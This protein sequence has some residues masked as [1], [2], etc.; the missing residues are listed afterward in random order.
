MKIR[1]RSL[2]LACLLC[3]ASA[4]AAAQADHA[5]AADRCEAAVTETIEK[6]RGKDA[7]D[8]QFVGAKRALSTNDDDEVG[9]KGEGRYRGAGGASIPF[10]YSCAF[11]AKS[12][13][14]SGVVFRETGGAKPAAADKPWQPDL[15]NVSPQ[16][17]EAAVASALKGKYPRVGG[18]SFS[19]A[20]RQVKPAADAHMSLEGQ[21]VMERAPGMSASPFRYRCEID[22]RSG[23]ILRAQT[24]E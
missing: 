6:L 1:F 15:S 14:T 2:G 23:K 18:I 22:P 11:N 19:A 20:T 3:A 12:S 7:Q 5:K 17:C 21:G 10:T 9:V 8:I 24:T 16:E 4:G 13:T